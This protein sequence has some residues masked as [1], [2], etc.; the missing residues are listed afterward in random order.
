MHEK[1]SG[2]TVHSS[3]SVWPY[4]TETHRH[5]H[6]CQHDPATQP[7]GTCMD[8]CRCRRLRLLLFKGLAHTKRK[9]CHYLFNLMLFQTHMTYFLQC[10][11][12]TSC[13][14]SLQCKWM[15]IGTVKLQKDKKHHKN[16][17]Y[18]L[19]TSIL[20]PCNIFKHLNIH[21]C[22]YESYCRGKE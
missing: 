2:A 21:I 12:L 4:T 6:T 3:L 20:K 19:C 13:F 9:H 15:H 14:F 11:M 5:A 18:D 1:G 22:K 10:R 8:R 7:Q 17:P 16:G